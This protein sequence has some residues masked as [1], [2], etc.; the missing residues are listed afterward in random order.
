MK[1]IQING[2]YG[3]FMKRLEEVKLKVEKEIIP[4]PIIFQKLCVNFSITKKQCWEVLFILRDMRLIEIV[5]FHG[6]KIID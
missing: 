3:I 1:T 2:L 5:P 4:F 6:I